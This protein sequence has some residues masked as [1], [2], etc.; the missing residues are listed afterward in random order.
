MFLYFKFDVVLV[1][2]ANLNAL[3]EVILEEFVKLV[4]YPTEVLPLIVNV[5]DQVRVVNLLAVLQLIQIVPDKD[6]HSSLQFLDASEY[7]FY[8]HVILVDLEGSHESLRVV[9]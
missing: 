2:N 6:R 4:A 5:V 8:R 7:F 3:S 1:V 9:R